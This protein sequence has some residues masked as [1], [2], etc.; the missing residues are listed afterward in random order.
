MA[1]TIRRGCR[2]ATPRR[3]P[4]V[5]GCSAGVARRSTAGFA[6]AAVVARMIGETGAGAANGVGAFH[7]GSSMR[8]SAKRERPAV[9]RAW[10]ALAAHVRDDGT[11]VDVCASTGSGPTRKYYLD[12][13]AI[14]GADDRG[15]AM[16]LLASMEIATRPS[17]R[18]REARSSAGRSVR[19]AR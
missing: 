4:A 2:S 17:S 8:S 11:I 6:V 18:L 1:L 3:A 14:T 15:G 19:S 16:A 10:R 9:A 5:L 7:S 13:P 12:R